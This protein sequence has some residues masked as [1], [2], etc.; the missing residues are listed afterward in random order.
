[1]K[2][3]R[4]KLY[5]GFMSF[6]TGISLG[7]IGCS[8]TVAYN[9]YHT[10]YNAEASEKIILISLVIIMLVTVSELIGAWMDLYRYNRRNHPRYNRKE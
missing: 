9:W 2:K 1:M 4:K 8:I 10:S 7:F 6:I 3:Y 5:I